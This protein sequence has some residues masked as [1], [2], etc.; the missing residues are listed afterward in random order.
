MENERSRIDVSDYDVYF[1][2]HRKSLVE[3]NGKATILSSGLVSCLRERQIGKVIPN[4]TL[5]LIDIMERE[6]PFTK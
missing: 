2:C 5:P 4:I 1:L 6:G 3:R